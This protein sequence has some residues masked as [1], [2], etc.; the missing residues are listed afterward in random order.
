MPAPVL[1]EAH[2]GRP[3]TVKAVDLITDFRAEGHRK[4]KLCKLEHNPCQTRRTVDRPET[5]KGV[6]LITDFQTD[7]HRQ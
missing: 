1:N 5:V 4:L 7:D 2:R 6:D 3:K